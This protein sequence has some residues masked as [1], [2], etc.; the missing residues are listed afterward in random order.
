MILHQD[1]YKDI[2]RGKIGEEMFIEQEKADGATVIDVR[3][4]QTFRALDTD[5]ILVDSSFGDRLV[6]VEVK[7]DYKSEQTGN[8]FIETYNTS[9][10][11]DGWW[12]Y[13][14]AEYL[15]FVQPLSRVA[16]IVPRLNIPKLTRYDVG[17][18]GS[19]EGR[20]VPICRLAQVE[21]YK[22]IK[23]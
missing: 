5:F 16:H 7:T 11:K 15:V 22:R 23:L 8:V 2:E 20:L 13:C 1:F 3:D 19:Q 6:T 14:K 12:Y 17:Y 4:N 10:G 18:C 21:G 9:T